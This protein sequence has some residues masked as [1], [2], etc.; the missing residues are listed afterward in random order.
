MQAFA[1]HNQLPRK[2]L[3]HYS[4]YVLATELQVKVWIEGE[5][6]IVHFLYQFSSVQFISVTQSCPTLCFFF[7]FSLYQPKFDCITQA[8]FQ[9]QS[10]E[11]FSPISVL[12]FQGLILRALHTSSILFAGK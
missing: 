9:I 6:V 2:D 5:F 12:V 1:Q 7:A 8:W 11:A 4:E 10:F 3:D